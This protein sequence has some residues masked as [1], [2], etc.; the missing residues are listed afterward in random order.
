M[1]FRQD[2]D[3][4]HTYF[5]AIIKFNKM[6]CNL[7][8]HSPYFPDL[9][10]SDC[11]VLP[12][13]KKW[14]CEN[15]FASKDRIIAYTNAYFEE[16]QTYIHRFIEKSRTY[17]INLVYKIIHLS[18]CHIYTSWNIVTVQ[19]VLLIISCKGKVRVS[20]TE[21]ASFLI[22]ETRKNKTISEIVKK[23]S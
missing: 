4:V 15:R 1:I 21:F 16:K 6:G 19:K 5:V 2:S 10:T 14:Q 3:K 9:A 8:P 11:L 20:E 7:F 22:T 17:W 12:K 13:L 23:Y 18:N